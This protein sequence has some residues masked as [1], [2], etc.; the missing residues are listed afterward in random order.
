MWAG[1]VIRSR[2]NNFRTRPRALKSPSWLSDLWPELR[3]LFELA[4][5]SLFG[6]LLKDAQNRAHEAESELKGMRDRLDLEAHL[7]S[8]SDGELDDR[9]RDTQERIRSRLADRKR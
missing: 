9:M 5:A 2:P 8:L 1:S 7:G 6:W 3:R 4:M